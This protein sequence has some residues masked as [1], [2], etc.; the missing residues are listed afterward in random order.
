[1]KFCRLRQTKNIKRNLMR[2]AVKG[3]IMSS[4]LIFYFATPSISMNFDFGP[5]L[6]IDLDTTVKYG[7]S[8]RTNDP[9]PDLL[10]DINGD[11]GNRA[12]DKGDLLSNR[13]S[14]TSELDLQYKNT[15]IFARGRAFYD[16]PY[17]H[18]SAHDSPGTHNGFVGG[19]LSDHQDFTD[20]TLDRHRSDVELFDLYVYGS[21]VLGDRDAMLRVGRQVVSW[22]ESLLT[23]GSISAAQS[24]ADG[25]QLNVPG[26]ELKDIFL[27]SWQAMG[28]IDLVRNL[29][30]AA[31]YQ[32]EWEANRLDEA[33]SFFSTSDMLDEGGTHYLG[34]PNY[35][36]FPRIEDDDP[37][38]TGQWGVSLRY[39]AEN[40]NAT[41]FGLYFLKYHEK[42]PLFTIDP[43]A[44]GYFLDYDE[45]VALIGASIST[46]VGDTNIGAEIAYRKDLSVRVQGALPTY[47]PFDVYQVLFNFIHYFGPQVFT[48]NLAVTF[49]GGF[50]Q[51]V[52]AKDLYA[53]QFAWGYLAKIAFD[54]YAILPSLDLNVPIVFKHKVSGDSSLAGTWNEDENEISVGL[55]FTYNQ[56][57]KF[58]FKYTEFL[59]D[60][61]DYAKSDRDYA[62]FTI[63]YTF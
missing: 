1:M 59:G 9:D 31:Y 33:G 46:V 3:M 12:F 27:P 48:D 30:F 2:R 23:F 13:I 60:A 38:D 29:T 26:V 28:Q 21:F 11:D 16:D 34:A 24:Y 20:D 15:G 44:G 45:D 17:N 37:S 18:A 4:I 42:M 40:L 58:G 54:Y 50:N 55:D 7:I 25:T 62:S 41:E 47:K 43:G 8:M 22:G 57:I 51:V 52:D 49:E 39:L 61:E 63:K 5:D 36:A 10:A 56:D 32:W 53:D 35:V 6:Q 14:L 19:S